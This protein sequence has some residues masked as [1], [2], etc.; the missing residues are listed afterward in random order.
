MSGVLD[1]GYFRDYRK[2]L[3]F[4]NQE[5]ARKFLAAKDVQPEIDVAYLS[6]LNSRLIEIISKMDGIIH[7]LLKPDNL[8]D[9][10]EEQV[11]Q[12][13]EALEK[14]GLLL[15]M[16][17][18]GR[19]REEVYF[20]WLRGRLFAAYFSKYIARMFDVDLAALSLIGDDEIID[21]EIFR[22]TPTADL[23]VDS[24]AFRVRIEVQSGF[25]GINDIKQHKV[26]EAKKVLSSEGTPTV[27]AHF[28]I[29]NGQVALVNVSGIAEDDINW[30]TRQQMEGQTVFNISQNH[31]AWKLSD[32]PVLD[33]A[34]FFEK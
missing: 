9:F 19:R 13:S 21:P 17:N 34:E 1:A 26:I 32:M 11:H 22:K 28:D 24:G 25:Q 8:G 30:I 7:P 5:E 29:F 31:F 18:L 16:N 14:T 4:T 6:R 12:V 23:L 27:V 20:S 3:G 10:I 33:V 15:R 2:A